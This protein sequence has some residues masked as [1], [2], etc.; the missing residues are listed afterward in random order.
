M[1]AGLLLAS[2]RAVDPARSTFDANGTMIR[3]FHPFTRE[4]QQPVTPNDPA[5]YRI[6]IYPTSAIFRKGDR[7]RLTIGS[8]DTPATSPPVPALVDSLGAEIRV[9]RGGRYES[10]VLLPFAPGYLPERG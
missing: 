2:Q 8:A 5:L 7:I 3:P 1:T 10:H 6:E 9:L 4:S